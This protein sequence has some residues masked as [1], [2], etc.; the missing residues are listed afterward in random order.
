[1]DN[2][3]RSVSGEEAFSSIFNQGPWGAA[4]F[5]NK[6]IWSAWGAFCSLQKGVFS[7]MSVA[8]FFF[9]FMVAVLMLG[10]S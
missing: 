1:M 10:T 3:L 8:F 6:G 7:L 5:P 4:G 9:S 2:N